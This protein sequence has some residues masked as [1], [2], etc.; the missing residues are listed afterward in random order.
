MNTEDEL[1]QAVAEMRAGT[2][3]K[4]GNEPDRR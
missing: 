2:F 1:R 4:T 3:I